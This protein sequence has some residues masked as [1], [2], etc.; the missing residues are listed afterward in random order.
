MRVATYGALEKPACQ[1]IPWA[2]NALQPTVLSEEMTLSGTISLAEVD[3]EDE[4]N[5]HLRIQYRYP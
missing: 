5:Q 3:N 1:N 4:S 2:R